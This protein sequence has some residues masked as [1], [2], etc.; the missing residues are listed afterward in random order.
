MAANIRWIL[1]Q[2]GASAKAVVW[3]ANSHVWVWKDPS[4]PN[5]AMGSHLRRMFGSDLVVFGFAFNEGAFQAQELSASVR[6]LRTFEVPPAPAGSL[7]AVLA[8]SDLDIAAIDLRTLPSSGPV[9]RWFAAPRLSRCCIGGVYSDNAQVASGFHLSQMVQNIYDGLLFVRRTT[10]SH[11]LEAPDVSRQ[12]L[13]QPGN[14]D[15]ELGEPSQVPPEWRV[16]ASFRRYDFDIVTTDSQCDSGSRCARISRTP[17]KHYGE[18][19]GTLTQ[20][21]DA[22][23]Y[24]GKSVTLQAAARAQQQGADNRSWVMLSVSKQAGGRPAVASETLDPVVSSR[25]TTFQVRAAVPNDA[26]TITFGLVLVGDGKAWLD[27]IVLTATDSAADKARP[28]R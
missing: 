11:P 12:K 14:I 17:G 20:T 22:A 16:P 3:A 1:E 8:A 7:D 9:N 19:A 25:W 28:N 2:E 15:F 4:A 6:R 5:A 26:E 18:V 27:S 10:S 24:R 13:A 21:I 23:P